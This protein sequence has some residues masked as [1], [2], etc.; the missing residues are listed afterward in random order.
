MKAKLFLAAMIVLVS[1][2]AF[3]GPGP[4][5]AVIGQKTN[6]TFK[7]IYEGE[8]VGKV[9]M[10]I[11]NQEAEVVFAETT[12]NVNGFI[13]SVNFAGMEQGTYTIEIADQKGTEAQTVV[14]SKAT[15]VKNVQVSKMANCPKYLLTVANSGQE[16][17]SVRI[18][19]GA[20]NLVHTDYRTIDG[21]FGMVY[22]L[23]NITGVPTFEIADNT[24][25][26]R[27]IRY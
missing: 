19:D 2:A 4:R 16:E 9:K 7:V 12:K 27:T 14:Y 21:N 26:I 18:Y 23:K 10:T 5:I 1:T 11:F 25:N 24:G 15:K 8:T 6:G 20:N 13:R 17:I 3:S 22:N